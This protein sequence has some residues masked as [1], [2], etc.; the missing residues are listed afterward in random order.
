MASST[1][2]KVLFEKYQ[3]EG[4]KQGLSIVKYCQMNGVV[5]SHFERWY[6][7]YRAGVVLPVE[8]VDIDG[9]LDQ[10]EK[11]PPSMPLDKSS[12]SVVS[13]THVNIVFS[14]MLYELEYE[15]GYKF[16]SPVYEDGHVTHF[17]LDFKYLVALIK[18]PVLS[19]LSISRH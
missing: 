5:Y 3:E 10:S 2:F 19:K 17:Q 14:N 12:S 18:C 8:I 1:D 13:V 6:K 7:K 15:R 11:I 9:L 4:I 16:M